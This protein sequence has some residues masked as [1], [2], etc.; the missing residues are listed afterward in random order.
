V[1]RFKIIG[2]SVHIE[3]REAT[4]GTQ[5]ATTCTITWPVIPATITNV[6]WIGYGSAND[7]GAG[8][9]ATPCILYAT[10]G[11]ATGTFY[12]DSSFAGFSGAG[13][14]RINAASI[15]YEI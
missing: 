3:Y 11:S 15:I 9:M 7:A 10:S 6:A 12:K 5:N 8:N 4:L 13:N 2:R 14:R 1:Y